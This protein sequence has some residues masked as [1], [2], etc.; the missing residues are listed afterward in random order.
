MLAASDYCGLVSGR[1]VDIIYALD[2]RYYQIG[3]PTGVGYREGRDLRQP[4]D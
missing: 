3:Q 2:N 1:D 4:A